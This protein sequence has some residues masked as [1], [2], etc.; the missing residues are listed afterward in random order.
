MACIFGC[1]IETRRRSHPCQRRHGGGSLGFGI[2]TTIEEGKHSIHFVE[3]SESIK[4]SQVDFDNT[5]NYILYGP[6]N[7][8]GKSKLTILEVKTKTV[9][10]FSLMVTNVVPM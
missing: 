6:K 7:S 5:R 10:F 4:S 8:L 9:C 1:P 3:S 2:L